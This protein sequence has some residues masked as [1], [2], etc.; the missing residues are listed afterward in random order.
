M[1]KIETLFIW[2]GLFSVIIVMGG[3][4]WNMQTPTNPV[5][6]N[7]PT[8]K[9][10]AFLVSQHA[11]YKN[12][13]DTA[14]KYIKQIPDSELKIIKDTVILSEFL[15][16]NM[17]SGDL[18]LLKDETNTASHF[19]YDAYLIKQNKWQSVYK[20]HK[21][22]DSSLTAPIRIWAS[23]ANGNTKEAIK[24]INKMNTNDSWKSFI[25]GQIYS[26]NQ[27]IDKAVAEFEK[28]SVNFINI[29]DYMYLMAFYK[30]NKLDSKAKELYSK[31]TANA[32]GMFILDMNVSP[33]WENYS[34]YTNELAFSLTQSVSHTQILIYSDVYLLMLRFAQIIQENPNNGIL[35]YYIGQYY[36]NN[37]GD[38][39]KYFNNIDKKNPMYPFSRMRIAEK[40]NDLNALVAAVDANP[41]FIPAITRLVA[42]NVQY[43]NKKTALKIVDKALKNKNL[44][45]SGRFFLLKT[46]AGIYLTFGDLNSAQQDVQAASDINQSDSDIHAAQSKIWA[47]QDNKLNTA[48]NY[49]LALVRKNP[50]NVEYWDALAIAVWAKDG[51]NAALDILARVGN[52][53]ET[54]SVLFEHLGDLY[55]QTGNKKLAQESY[56]RAISLSNDGLTVIPTLKYKLKKLK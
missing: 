13:F 47:L 40:E 11:I 35:Y 56:N 19:I 12:D 41:L 7:Y 54:C 28:V 20:R 15:C 55:K 53:S 26:E 25:I 34:G 22:D 21:K 44:T 4:L 16:G 10:G 36:F 52:V 1:K 30:Q 18:E 33:N 38:Y 6:M 14:A 5:A 39:K 3:L 17:P 51:P 32:G 8:N 2:V 23:V 46:R 24:F 31:F 27:E 50:T 42:K 43:G 37:G 49:A 45:E 48:Y 9:Y 29:N